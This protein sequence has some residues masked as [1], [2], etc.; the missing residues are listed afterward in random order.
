MIQ[1]WKKK[2]NVQSQIV[3]VLHAIYQNG[4][5]ILRVVHYYT[6]SLALH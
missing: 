1:N 5:Y 2:K 4:L 6:L 3:Y